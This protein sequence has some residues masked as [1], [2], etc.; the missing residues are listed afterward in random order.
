MAKW[1]QA[2]ALAELDQR[3]HQTEELNVCSSSSTELTQWFL[4]TTQFLKEVFGEY[5]EGA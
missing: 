1:S 4:I 3:I 5:T 2:N